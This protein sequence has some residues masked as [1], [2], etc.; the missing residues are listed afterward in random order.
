MI[1]QG[2]NINFNEELDLFDK[3][4]V[5]DSIRICYEIYS[6]T[7]LSKEIILI[8]YEYIYQFF[9]IV[10]DFPIGDGINIL[11]IKISPDGLIYIISYGKLEIFK[12][13]LD[14][15]RKEQTQ[16]QSSL[17]LLGNV[18][19]STFNKNVACM[20]IYEN[21]IFIGFKYGTITVFNNRGWSQ[22]NMSNKQQWIRE[23]ILLNHTGYIKSIT[24]LNNYGYDGIIST[25]FD[26]SIRI[27]NLETGECD[28]RLENIIF[29][30]S[31][32]LLPQNDSSFCEFIV[33][34]NSN[35][36]AWKIKRN[37]LGNFEYSSSNINSGKKYVTYLSNINDGLRSQRLIFSCMSDHQ[38]WNSNTYKCD[39]ILRGHTDLIIDTDVLPNGQLITSSYDHNI[40]IWTIPQTNNKSTQNIFP[41]F[42]ISRKFIPKDGCLTTFN[43]GQIGAITMIE[44]KYMLTIIY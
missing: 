6:K 14:Y 26:N 11:N 30:I 17:V 40:N 23:H 9:G 32:I 16:E 24:K 3:S 1:K 34:S 12:F 21:R 25:S 4:E 43:N 2:L 42:T 44:N 38:I 27:W 20:M 39:F 31:L 28:F 7:K 10:R 29:P 15:D 18:N 8:I 33:G 22:E 35:I 41:S 5:R 37:D 19:D 36:G 13:L